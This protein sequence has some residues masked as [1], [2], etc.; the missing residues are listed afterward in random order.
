M[1]ALAIETAN[2]LED[3]LGLEPGALGTTLID[4]FGRLSAGLCIHEAVNGRCLFANETLANLMRRKPAQIVGHGMAD[5]LDPSAPASS[6][7]AAGQPVLNSVSS[8]GPLALW[9]TVDG[10][11]RHFSIYQRRIAAIDRTAPRL[12]CSVWVETERAGFDSHS[13]APVRIVP[14]TVERLPDWVAADR[15]SGLPGPGMAA[16]Q[17]VF[18]ERCRQELEWCGR[19]SQ[20]C[21]IVSVGVDDFAP[22]LARDGRRAEREVARIVEQALQAVRG[23]RDACLRLDCKRFTMLLSGVGLSNAHAWAERVLRHCANHAVELDGAFSRFTVSVGVASYPHTADDSATL[24][25]A[26]NEALDHALARGGD[27]IAL[28]S[29]RFDG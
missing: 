18:D 16:D 9:L 3:R 27:Q 4:M 7:S 17:S 8:D 2:D 1:T 21:S 13:D 23:E 6:D 29:I 28:A 12:F 5:W 24:L 14:E 25:A 11:V 10:E 20:E 15:S 22:N 26:A 19:E